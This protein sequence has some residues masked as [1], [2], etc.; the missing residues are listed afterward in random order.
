MAQVP[1]KE[2]RVKINLCAPSTRRKKKKKNKKKKKKKRVNIRAKMS[3][4]RIFLCVF[5]RGA[6]ILSLVCVCT[7]RTTRSRVLSSRQDEPPSEGQS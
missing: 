1:I 5:S 6:N 3:L 2:E 7:R 4:L